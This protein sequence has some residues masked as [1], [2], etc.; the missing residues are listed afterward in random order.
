MLSHREM[1]KI[2]ERSFHIEN[3]NY[4]F[5]VSLFIVFYYVPYYVSFF[6]SILRLKIGKE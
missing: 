6:I 4:V 5:I 2:I 1:I 3:L